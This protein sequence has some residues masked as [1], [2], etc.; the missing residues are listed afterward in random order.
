MYCPE[1]SHPSFAQTPE[2]K[3][4]PVYV[5]TGTATSA[6]LTPGMS[7]PSRSVLGMKLG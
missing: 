4:H 7:L 3:A 6:S 5:A 2:R 1:L